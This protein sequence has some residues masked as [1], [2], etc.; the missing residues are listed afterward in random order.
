M[1]V[2]NPFGNSNTPRATPPN[3]PPAPSAS[4]GPGSPVF[5]G[6]RP[7]QMAETHEELDKTS[8]V[9]PTLL[10]EARPPAGREELWNGAVPF[11]ITQG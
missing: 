10:D 1:A 8:M 3:M 9:A 6:A 2:Q 4:R 5:M 11:R 7:M